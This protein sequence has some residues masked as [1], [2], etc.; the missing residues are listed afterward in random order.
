MGAW[1][2]LVGVVFGGRKQQERD[3]DSTARRT[4]PRCWFDKIALAG[5]RK[6][7]KNVMTGP[8]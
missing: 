4:F 3:T 6:H 2:S 8:V 1:P 7:V 5:F